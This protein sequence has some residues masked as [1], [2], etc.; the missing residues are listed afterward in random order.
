MK[1]LIRENL[2]PNSGRDFMKNADMTAIYG[3][4]AMFMRNYGDYFVIDE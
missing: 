4:R 2:L 1:K 3:E